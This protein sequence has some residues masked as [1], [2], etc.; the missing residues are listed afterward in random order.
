MSEPLE[1]LP[2]RGLAASGPAADV[3]LRACLA[4]ALLPVPIMDRGGYQTCSKSRRVFLFVL[5]SVHDL[6]Q[7]AQL[8][9]S[10]LPERGFV[11]AEGAGFGP[12]GEPWDRRVFFFRVPF[13]RWP[14]QGIAAST[15]SVI[16]SR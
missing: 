8:M 2:R 11:D 1:L 6:D 3:V 7:S 16:R 4:L 14:I 5:S 12:G 13:S 15:A 10:R 9:G